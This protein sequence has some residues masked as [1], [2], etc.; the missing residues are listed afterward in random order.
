[1]RN[2]PWLRCLLLAGAL[3]MAGCGPGA[4]QKAGPPPPREVEILTLTKK[5]V[6]ETA[7]YLGSVISRQS[8]N[9]LPQVGG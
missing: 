9:L 5:P 8:V 7:E 2:R 1:M 4:E 6:R 3:A